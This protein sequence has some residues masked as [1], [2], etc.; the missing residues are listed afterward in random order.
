MQGAKMGRWTRKKRRVQ[1]GMMDK[2]DR[3]LYGR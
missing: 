1:N 3:I 2:E